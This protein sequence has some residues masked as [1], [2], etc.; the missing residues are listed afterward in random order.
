MQALC[1]TKL[2]YFM[3]QQ[4][5]YSVFVSR[6]ACRALV[7]KPEG[8]RPLGRPK[9][10]QEDNIKMDLQDMRWGG[11]YWIGLAQGKDR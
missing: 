9:H 3:Q 2:L 4:N 11:M 6:G 1:V 5:R 10:R 7:G 8:R